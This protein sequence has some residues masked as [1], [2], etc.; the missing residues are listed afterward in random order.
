MYLLYPLLL[1]SATTSCYWLMQLG[2]SPIRSMIAVIIVCNAII[3]F[4]EWLYPYK[5]EWRPSRQ[6]LLLDIAHTL[7]SARVITPLIKV[8]IVYMLSQFAFLNLE[9][10][11]HHL[12]MIWQVVIAIILGDLTIYIFHRWMHSSDL[13]WKIHVVHHSPSKLHFWASARSHPIN[14]AFTYLFEVGLLMILGTSIEALSIWTV[15]MSL[16]GLFQHCNIDLKPGILNSILATSDV[17]R[18]HHSTNWDES[19]SNFGNTTVLWDRLFG[20]YKKPSHSINKVGIVNHLIPENYLAHLKAP[21][22]LD[23]FKQ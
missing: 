7:V 1:L 13:G 12:P 3:W 10:W 6:V 23:G 5:I 15:F 17:H 21:F 20:T 9:V 18:I 16:N 22:K 8:F 14:V 4:Y 19:N 11:P 2:H